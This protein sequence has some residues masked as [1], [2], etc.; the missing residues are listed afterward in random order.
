MTRLHVAVLDEELPFPLTSGKRIRS[1]QLLTRL[2]SRHRVTYI[3]HAVAGSDELR[4]AARALRQHDIFVVPVE[5]RL[6]PKSGPLFYARLAR[7]VFS[8]LPYSVTSHSS[9]AMQ[10][11]MDKLQSSDP[12]DLW[13]CEWTP[14]AQ[15]MY[16]R[17][18]RWVVMAHNVEALIWQRLSENARGMAARWFMRRQWKRFEAFEEWAYNAA[19]RA[20][21]VS[22]DDARLMRERYRVPNPAVVDNGVDS[23][24][25]ARPI[26]A[27]RQPNRF[28]FLGSLDWRPNQ[29]AVKILVESIFPRVQAAEPNALLDIVGRRP[30]EWLQAYGA[31]PGITVHADVPDVR[32]F[33]HRSTALAVPLR[34]GGGS[35]LKI[36]EALAA[37]CPVV[38]TTVGVEG[39]RLND[40][41]HVAVANEAE[42][43]AAELV[44]T[45]RDPDRAQAAAERGRSKVEVEYGWDKLAAQLAEVWESACDHAPPIVPTPKSLPVIDP[46]RV[47][48]LPADL[49]PSK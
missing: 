17:P 14:Y 34:I 12:P 48:T 44:N 32:P 9:Q 39:L 47:P 27:V 5:H 21:A 1:F 15:A 23:A 41:E 36:L 28:L 42:Q 13:H 46:W 22:E 20:I 7:S 6:P 31:R 29:D 43:F 8:A 45:M 24:F 26:D 10:V 38:T 3:A 40:G 35:R 11:A 4:E 18:G 25:F 19:A 16:R 33:L 30:P 49:M 37:G 2:A